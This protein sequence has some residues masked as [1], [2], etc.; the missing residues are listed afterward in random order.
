MFE[1]LKKSVEKLL[2]NVVKTELKES[3]IESILWDFKLAL[4][5][6]D[7]ALSVADKICD[8]AKLKLVGS[9][10]KRFEDKKKIVENTLREILHDVL[11]TEKKVDLLDLAEKK[12]EIKEPLI[13]VFIGINGTGKTTTIGKI[14]SLLLKKKYSVV[15]AGSDTHRTG[16]LEQLE[17]HAKNLGV[18]LIKHTYGADAAAVAFD[19][20]NHAKAHG[21]NV[22]LID[23]A[24][25]MQTNKNLM[26]EMRKIIKVTKP[27]LIFF[28]GDALTGNDAV[29]QAA[30]FNKYINFDASILTKT[31]A[32]TRGGAA[33][34]IAYVTKK[35]TIYLGTGQ[36]YE[37]LV[38]FK[39]EYIIEK[40]FPE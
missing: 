25:R 35:P 5:E 9:A 20:I 27:D 37:D 36:S 33:I 15:F 17:G 23:T 34:S 10:I 2:D 26:E 32:D 11:V 12:K 39:P 3:E 30:D 4:I 13:I 28:V 22:V 24:G 19:A 40:I 31:D 29:E 16:S 21:I 6:N 8:D 1:G 14:A 7:I 18:R 38:L